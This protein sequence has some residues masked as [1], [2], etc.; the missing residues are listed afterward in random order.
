MSY[1][2]TTW[3]NQKLAEEED[4]TKAQ[5]G[6]KRRQEGLEERRRTEDQLGEQLGPN[7]NLI[8]TCMHEF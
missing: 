2:F 6:P 8:N 1:I 5:T 7:L 4:L 3:L